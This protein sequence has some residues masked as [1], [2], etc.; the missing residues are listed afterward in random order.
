MQGFAVI[1]NRPESDSVA[2]WV[3]SHTAPQQASNSNAVTI[4]R[5]G[6]PDALRKVRSLTRSHAVLL[7]D[8]S[9][10]DT[11]P[12]EGEPLTVADVEALVVETAEQQTLILEAVAAYARRTRNRSLVPPV[13]PMPPDPR[14]FNPAWDDA[15]QRAF[16][17][18][19]YLAHAWTAWLATDEQR[20]RRSIQPRT[21]KTPW[22]MPEDM[23]S[24]QIAKFPPRF[25]ALVQ[26]QALV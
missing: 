5:H 9:T 12:V 14:D 3:T 25:T 2:V 16:Q 22:M 23:S 8:G 20:R 4:D 24:P 19:N 26:P 15:T 13:F 17:T 7:T 18:A 10:L 11:L 21:D 6:D 1:D